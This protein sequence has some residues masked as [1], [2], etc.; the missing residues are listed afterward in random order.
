MR[1]EVLDCH[2]E[3]QLATN[4]I[5]QGIWEPVQATAPSP[6]GQRRPRVGI[7]DD[8]TECAFDFYREL[9]SQPFTLEVVVRY[10]RN[11][12]LIGGLKEVHL[13]EEYF[14]SIFSNTTAAGIE[15]SSPRS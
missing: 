15:A 5:Q 9:Q 7:L 13:H 1:V 14:F 8:A 2:D 6:L 12:F 11:E 10:G 4:L 3:D